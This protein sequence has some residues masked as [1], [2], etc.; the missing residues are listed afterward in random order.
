MKMEK[1]K[2]LSNSE[3]LIKAASYCAYQERCHKEVLEKLAE[4]GA[5]GQEADLILLKLIEDNYV[6]EERYAKAFAGGKFRVK[7]W[8]RQKIKRE[9]KM[10]EISD[11]CVAQALNEIE[12]D[13]YL[14]TL[15]GLVAAKLKSVK[16][17]NELQRKHKTHQYLLSRGYES[18]LIWDCLNGK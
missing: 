5:Y 10:R 7:R 18:N 14:E 16:A 11:Y 13:A 17:T 1:K 8:G 4:L 9:L 2:Y 12:E 15:A 6:N 3:I